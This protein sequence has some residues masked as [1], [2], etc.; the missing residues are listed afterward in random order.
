MALCTKFRTDNRG[1]S[2]STGEV[3][4]TLD[5]IQKEYPRASIIASS[6]DS[7]VKDVLPV[8]HKLPVVTSEIGDTWIYGVPSDPLKISQNRE[9]QRVW[10]EC[11]EHEDKDLSAACSMNNY[12]IQNMTRFLLK[13]P[14]H[15]WGLPTISS[16]VTEDF[17]KKT[18]QTKVGTRSYLKAAASW[19][20]Q[21]I[22]NELAVQALEH[23]RHPIAK[24]A[25][26]RVEAL[27]HV[28]SIDTTGLNKVKLG[29]PVILNY[30]RLE[31]SPSG[32]I[33]RLFDELTQKEWASASH[34]LGS[35]VYQTLNDTDWKFFARNYMNSKQMDSG[36][37]KIG[38]N[39]Y[40]ESKLW[41]PELL[42][43][44]VP[45]AAN[46]VVLELNMPH[47]ASYYYGAPQKLYINVTIH[48]SV[49]TK[50]D[51]EVDYSLTWINKSATLIG[52][53]S[54][55]VF[56]PAGQ[57][58]S[59]WSVD[60]L[61]SEI[62]PEQ[63]LAGGNQMNHAVW[64]GARV[65]T[66]NGD[67]HIASLDAAVFC[68]TTPRFPMGFPLPGASEGLLPLVRDSVNGFGV[69]L[70]NN[71]WNTNYPAYYPYYDPVYCESLLSCRD[72]SL[73]FR[74]KLRFKAR[75]VGTQVE[76]NK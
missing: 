36:F 19:S 70:H 40:S 5:Y 18:F 76:A 33:I 73:V 24:E 28:G 60:K 67:F 8:K 35:F 15:T 13:I 32:Q 22:Y 57:R 45:D 37:S 38:S 39:K 61:G 23:A 72:S 62:D 1:P 25:R 68:P 31:F 44:Y 51:L 6:F 56:K 49:Q 65:S 53:S 69:N 54:M 21:R 16:M 3:V 71:L 17:E 42:A 64:S 7:F 20:E 55:L 46:T 48:R 47:K 11:L 27:S 75:E 14:E 74:F 30:V 26:R 50:G 34:A 52:E 66:T 4:R 41:S 2:R 63:V 58:I 43:A 10:I 59:S 9:I 12:A 29:E